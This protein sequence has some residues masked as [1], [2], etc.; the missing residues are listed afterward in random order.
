MEENIKT[1]FIKDDKRAIVG[2]VNG[3]FLYDLF[4]PLLGVF[5]LQLVLQDNYQYMI[6]THHYTMQLILMLITSIFTLVAA[7]FIAKPMNLLNSYKFVKPNKI[8]FIL[9]C[10]GSMILFSYAYNLI[11]FMFNV[12]ISGGNAN[13]ENVLSLI[14]GNPYL[15]FVS[16]VIM[17][18]ILEEVT[19][20]Y[21]LF[22]GMAKY[23]RKWAI[24]VSGFIFMSVHAVASFVNDVDNIVRELL[25]LPPYMFSGMVL[26]YAYDKSENLATS[27]IIHSL[28]NLISFILCLL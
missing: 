19:Y 4:W 10:L 15:S 18:P 17:A 9:K 1:P 14:K 3:I 24:I 23:D 2:C 13:Q 20:R 5:L 6:N 28:N 16:M 26:A 25:L 11:L 12:D 8:G 7:L 22:G 27:S 21:F